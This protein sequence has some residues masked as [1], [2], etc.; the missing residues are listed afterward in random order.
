M[1]A[2]FKGPIQAAVCQSIHLGLTSAVG[3]L[4]VSGTIS[5]IRTSGPVPNIATMHHTVK[6]I[7]NKESPTLW[8]PA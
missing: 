4:E 2:L 7:P 3:I 8:S 5:E 6:G 1:Y